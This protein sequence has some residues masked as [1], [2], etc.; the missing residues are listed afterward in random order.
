MENAEQSSPNGAR[1]PPVGQR[2]QPGNPGGPGRRRK[3]AAYRELE[4]MTREQVNDALQRM[5]GPALDKLLALVAAK[6]DVDPATA[7]R[8]AAL[9]LDRTQGPVPSA[10]FVSAQVQ[11][12]GP[13]Y[14]AMTPEKLAELARNTLARIE[15]AKA[16][17]AGDG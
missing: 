11:N 14:V 4:K 1:K 8:A 10:S 15:A 5:V 16:E 3:T 13:G 17:D 2:F 12:T 6:K 9:L 7:L